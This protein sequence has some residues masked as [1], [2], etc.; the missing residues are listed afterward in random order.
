MPL[1]HQRASGCPSLPGA[2]ADTPRCP[3]AWRGASI[4]EAESGSLGPSL[5]TAQVREVSGSHRALAGA[6]RPD[7]RLW[8]VGWLGCAAAISG[9]W[10]YFS[11]LCPLITFFPEDVAGWG[12]ELPGDLGTKP[13]GQSQL[14]QTLSMLATPL[15]DMYSHM[16]PTSLS[17]TLSQ[18][19][20]ASRAH[21]PQVG[22]QQ[23]PTLGLDLPLAKNLR[24]YSGSLRDT[25]ALLL[26]EVRPSPGTQPKGCPE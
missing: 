9:V 24:E 21:C 20:R 18:N 17:L 5:S 22:A 3:P 6:P 12:K 19:Q 23:H 16:L 7:H 8:W 26:T 1:T 14:T 15:S 2:S 13:Q 25:R 11:V 10:E 4:V